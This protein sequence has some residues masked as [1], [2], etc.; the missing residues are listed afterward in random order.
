MYDENCFSLKT[1]Q[2]VNQ[3]YSDRML[4][5]WHVAVVSCSSFCW[6]L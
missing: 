4:L 5:R 6:E 1:A 3:L 2:S